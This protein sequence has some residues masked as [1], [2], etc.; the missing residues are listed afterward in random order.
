MHYMEGRGTVAEGVAKYELERNGSGTFDL[1]IRGKMPHD[2][3]V[4]LSAGIA[5]AGISIERGKARKVSTLVWEG[6]FELKPVA[7]GADPKGIDYLGFARTAA[8][9]DGRALSIEEF[10][11]RLPA[12]SCDA[13]SLEIR[14][15]DQTGFLGALL[16]RLSFFSLFP[17]EMDIETTAGK[18]CDRFRLKG[19]GGQLPSDAVVAVLRRNLE[20][21][22][23]GNA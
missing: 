8:K 4:N 1:K 20:G 2:W 18:I 5:G 10:S 19:V 14:A 22:R 9:A 15:N 3:I 16:D 7:F 23:A 17:E 11:L 6:T 21:L 13:L 12:A